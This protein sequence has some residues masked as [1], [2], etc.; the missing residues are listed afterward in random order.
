MLQNLYP[1]LLAF[2]GFLFWFVLAAA[3]AAI[4]VALSGWTG[5]KP[6]S[7]N[8]LRFSILFVVVM[9]IEF[10]IGLL[11]YLGASPV[12]RAA[13]LGHAVIM[14][15]AV[16]CAHVGGALS[17]KGRTDRMKSRGAAIAYAISLILLLSNIPWRALI[18][19]AS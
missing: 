12:A 3:L 14:F 19:F 8:L 9:D 1:Y 7:T 6:P 4:F 17:R 18:R 11:L 5:T 10:I 16:V 2:H 13:V 15:L